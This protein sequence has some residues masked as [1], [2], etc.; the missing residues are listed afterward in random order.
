MCYFCASFMRY[1]TLSRQ[2][3]TL[4]GPIFI[5]TLLVMMLGAV[6]TFMLSRHSDSSVAAVGLVNQL[7]NLVFIVFEVISLGT[8]I[9]CSQ[10]LG[11]GM[12]D[13]VVQVVGVSLLFNAFSGLVISS[14]LYLFADRIL[15]MMGMRPDI[16]PDGLA[17]M[18]TVG[19]FAFL[20]AISMALSASLRSADKA[21]YPMYVAIVVNV[22]NIV[23]N[24]TLIFGK[25]GFPEL[26]VQGAAI[27]T[28][29][30]RGVSAVLLF[31]ILLRK[32]IPSF[33]RRLFAP[34]PWRELRKLLNIGIPSA[35]EQ[36]SY[37]LSQ[38][39]I[40]YFINMIGNDALAT[41][42]YC[43]NIVMFTYLFSIAM[44]QGGA[45]S[46][47]HLV[48][49]GKFRAAYTL[50]KRVMRLSVGASFSLSLLTA[51]AGKHILALLTD[52]PWIIA[53]GATVLWIDVLL[54]AGRAVNLF[55]V[56]ALR[57]AGDI[58]FPVSVGIVVMWSC[59]VFGSW[60]LG[61]HMG[62]GL[63]AMWV[64]FMLDED[65]RGV[66]F[67]H[68]WNSMKWAGKQFTLK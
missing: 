47:G 63:V 67:I 21:K 22:I 13:K 3:A 51:L 54:E 49:R 4:A 66:V 25:F 48:G 57:S 29:F 37:S 52:N 6:D 28:C 45:I 14:C 31:V 19:G 5:E 56:N 39:V 18:R 40:S 58:Y 61:I 2:L 55:A 59:A 11:A 33:P 16:L 23:G 65:V 42:T 30:C 20:Q 1:G 12:K 24:Y 8:S 27:S 62:W 50:G 68:R 26:G 32:H 60:L 10:Y 15:L 41:R 7:L 38:V 64:A 53:T 43:V 17:Y 44:A 35:G 34:F 46:I 9:L 36:L